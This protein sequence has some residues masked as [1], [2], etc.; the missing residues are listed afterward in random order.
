MSSRRS[1]TDRPGVKNEKRSSTAHDECRV[2]TKTYGRTLDDLVSLDRLGHLVNLVR[3]VLGRRPAVGHVV[4][5]PKV[6]V[7]TARVVARR[8]EDPAVSLVFAD[9]IGRGGGGQDRV[10]ADDELFD[11]IGRP[12]LED[13]LDGL[14]RKVATV[15]SDDEG[16]ATGVDGIKDGLDKVFGVVLQGERCLSGRG[17]STKARR[18]RTG[19]WNTLTLCAVGQRSQ[20]DR[21]RTDLFL[22]PDVPGFWPSKGLV[23]ISLT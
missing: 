11:A 2:V 19:C 7:R 15:A 23:G 13:G 22:S 20:E 8:Q 9:H 4:L 1:L 14:G 10:L 3:H 12:D 17:L 6:V 18:S 16:C 21:S 5:D